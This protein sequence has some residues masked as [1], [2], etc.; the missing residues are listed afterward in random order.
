MCIRDSVRGET[1]FNTCHGYHIVVSG[2]RYSSDPPLDIIGRPGQDVYKR[3][4]QFLAIY[5]DVISLHMTTVFVIGQN[6]K[7]ERRNK[8]DD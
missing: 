8:K 5:G 6:P 2:G 4:E 1:G 7:C 3:Q